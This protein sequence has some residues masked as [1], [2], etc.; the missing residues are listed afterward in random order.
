MST[1]SRAQIEQRVFSWGS[2]E[3]RACFLASREAAERVGREVRRAMRAYGY[4]THADHPEFVHIEAD[5]QWTGTF[6]LAVRMPGLAS[7]DPSNAEKLA[8]QRARNALKAAVR[9][10]DTV[11]TWTRPPRRR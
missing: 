11:Q 5:Q 4:R 7:R 10:E 1:Y 3:Q 8:V 6:T 2:S 9:P